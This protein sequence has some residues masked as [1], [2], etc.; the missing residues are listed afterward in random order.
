MK[1]EIIIL[2]WTEIESIAWIFAG[3]IS[4]NNNA[5]RISSNSQ[6]TK[7][8]LKVKWN[9]SAPGIVHIEKHILNEGFQPMSTKL[10][11]GLYLSDKFCEQIFVEY[12][13]NVFS[14]IIKLVSF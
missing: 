2:R 8:T 12:I 9:E 7:N 13:W 3:C 10:S 4:I 11:V 5:Y 6:L 14:W 1:F